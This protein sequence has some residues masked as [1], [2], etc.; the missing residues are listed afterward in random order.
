MSSSSTQSIPPPLIDYDTVIRNIAK[1]NGN[2]TIR[3]I[4]EFIEQ[5]GID[6]AFAD[7]PKHVEPMDNN[8]LLNHLRAN[9]DV[10]QQTRQLVQSYFT[11]VENMQDLDT[12]S[13]K[14]LKGVEHAQV[15]LENIIQEMETQK[16]G[17]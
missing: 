7:V 2:E 5:E 11:T 12:Q 9:D 1:A 6:I 8:T 3:N 13:T 17:L 15:A 16:V 10:S 14:A 4:H